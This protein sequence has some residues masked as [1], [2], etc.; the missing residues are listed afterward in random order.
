MKKYGKILFQNL[1]MADSAIEKSKKSL[2]QNNFSRDILEKVQE[3]KLKIFE[4]EN[5]ANEFNIRTDTENETG[6]FQ[7]SDIQ[8][9]NHHHLTK[10]NMCSS[11]FKIIS[12]YLKN[13]II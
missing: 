2:T 9:K 6:T 11:K 3:L 5:S 8:L 4:L 13:Q 12:E 7:N 10:C 1:K